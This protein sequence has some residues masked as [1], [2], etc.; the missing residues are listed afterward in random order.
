MCTIAGSTQVPLEGDPSIS[1][2]NETN[3]GSYVCDAFLRA[4]PE[5]VQHKTG[6]I[7]VCLMVSGGIRSGIAVSWTS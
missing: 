6:N 5:S 2:K 3:L 1:R 7:T 4:V